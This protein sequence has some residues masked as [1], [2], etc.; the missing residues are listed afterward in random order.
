MATD[1]GSKCH[2]G[3]GRG[4]GGGAGEVFWWVNEYIFG[5]WVGFSP[6]S[7]VSHE[8]LGEQ[9]GIILGDNPAGHCFVLRNLVPMS[10]FK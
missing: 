9:W 4:G 5:C 1:N 10:S 6:I 3:V 8:C 2:K 7:R